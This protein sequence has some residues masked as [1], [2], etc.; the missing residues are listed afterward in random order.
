[1]LLLWQCLERSCGKVS[2]GKSFEKEEREDGFEVKE[3]GV[4]RPCAVWRSD[5]LE[6]WFSVSFHFSGFGEDPEHVGWN[7][8]LIRNEKARFP[9]GL[10]QAKSI[11]I[12]MNHIISNYVTRNFELAHDSEQLQLMWNYFPLAFNCWVKWYCRLKQNIFPN[13][14]F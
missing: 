12:E 9:P 3:D 4:Q 6:M 10:H 2:Q 8:N 14:F 7:V 1:M 11:S 5:L 13:K